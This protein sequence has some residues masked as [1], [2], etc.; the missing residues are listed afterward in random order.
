MKRLTGIEVQ[1]LF[2]ITDKNLKAL[3]KDGLDCLM[4]DGAYYYEYDKLV[5]VLA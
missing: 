1:A 4:I 5:E 2:D 3:R